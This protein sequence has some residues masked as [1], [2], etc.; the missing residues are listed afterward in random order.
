MYDAKAA[1]RNRYKVFD[2]SVHSADLDRLRLESDLVHAIERDQLQVLYQPVME[3]RT[4]DV[5]G[6]EALLRWEH[7]ELGTISPLA[8]IP[9]AE[10]T[11]A[12]VPIGRWCSTAPASRSAAGS[13]P[14]RSPFPSPWL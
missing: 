8:F 14:T 5:V 12:I 6:F 4:E 3:L 1:G 10:E 7:P 9:I 2:P 11:G 13:R